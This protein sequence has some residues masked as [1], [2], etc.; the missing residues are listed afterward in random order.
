MGNREKLLIAARECLERKGYTRTTARDV[1]EAAGTSLAA[2]GYHFGSTEAMLNTALHQAMEEWGDRLERTIGDAGDR[3][4]S[5]VRRF[6]RVWA[7][8]VASFEDDRALW[9]VLS[10]MLVQA[11]HVPELRESLTASMAEG[12]SGLAE[13][14][15]DIAAPADPGSARLIGSL[16]Q[17]LLTGLMMQW[18][19]DPEHSLTS[20][21]LTDAFRLLATTALTEH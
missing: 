19:I 6:E 13:I 8:I 11:Q 2:I 21:E 5:P 15:G 20:G 4:S 16:C 12:R 10:E 7:Q 14:F 3:S 9:A 17:T 18:L 1:T